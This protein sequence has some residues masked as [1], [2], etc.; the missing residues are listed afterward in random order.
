M[1]QSQGRDHSD[2][3]LK[4]KGAKVGAAMRK[5]CPGELVSKLFMRQ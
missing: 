5:G 2:Y 4:A 3:G 1:M